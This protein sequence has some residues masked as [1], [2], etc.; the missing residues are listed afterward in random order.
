M[1]QR[2]RRDTYTD[3]TTLLSNIRNQRTNELETYTK[4]NVW[5]D[6]S[7]MNDSKVDGAV[8][9]KRG[10]E[11]FKKSFSDRII[12]CSIF[13][14]GFESLKKA[15]DFIRASQI[16]NG[17]KYSNLRLEYNSVYEITEQIVFQ[18]MDIHIDMNGSTFLFKTPIIANA[19]I[20]RFRN[21]NHLLKT[22]T[23]IEEVNGRTVLTCNNVTGL[24]KGQVIKL[25]SNDDLPNAPTRSTG[26]AALGECLFID[27][28]NTS[29]N[30]VTCT[31]RTIYNYNHS[32]NTTRISVFRDTQV[33]IRNGIFDAERGNE[34]NDIIFGNLLEFVQQ[35]N[36]IVSNIKCRFGYNSMIW[37][38][39]CWGYYINKLSVEFLVD[40]DTQER[41]GYGIRSTNSEAGT[42]DKCTFRNCRHGFV[43]ITQGTGTST[44]T[45]QFGH[46]AHH[47]ISNSVGAGCSNSPFD[48]HHG[49]YNVSF[50]NCK[51]YSNKQ[52]G[53]QLRGMYNSIDNC[54]SVND[55]AGVYIFIQTSYSNV[56]SQ[57]VK[58][59]GN[60]IN[61]FTCINPFSQAIRN[62]SSETQYVDGYT[63]I[64]DR[65]R[66]ST[67]IIRNGRDDSANQI[68]G[69]N[70]ILEG[71][72][73]ILGGTLE[74][75]NSP[76]IELRGNARKIEING[77]NLNAV[78][79][80]GTA[81]ELVSVNFTSAFT[82]KLRNF[83]VEQSAIK[84]RR[85][86]EGTAGN[87]TY[88]S[89]TILENIR[90]PATT[91]NQL[92]Q[93]LAVSTLSSYA[94]YIRGIIRIP[95]CGGVN[96]VHQESL[97]ANRFE[98]YTIATLPT[99]STR[100]DSISMIND[101]A[102]GKGRLIYSNGIV[103]RYVSD[104]STV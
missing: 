98:S 37:M 34:S 96:F 58:T 66:E 95:N 55:R 25:V 61:N 88:L 84:F 73:I 50:K 79:Y 100:A 43:S 59:A 64:L 51:S 39:G 24:E 92:F 21:T 60:R 3:G 5:A 15:C 40:N 30:K 45:Q 29:N 1:T 14:S 4:T 104:D 67:G 32:I 85:L 97:V 23:L 68:P 90:I 19:G 12:D 72:K 11:Y 46:D 74:I 26:A 18:N 93:G 31:A 62:E 102:A 7:V 63:I 49:S 57:L 42:V 81:F 103:W 75:L 38:F 36:P 48:T 2:H 33:S 13:G 53:Y 87:P 54:E 6:G 99:A 80:T 47:I 22:V 56:G 78:N 65:V 86:V 77:L 76:L 91:S 16:G 17:I 44:D 8:Y 101:P 52:A 35:K 89:D 70:L 83:E 94:P 69:G 82:L 27:S 71:G 41:R 28:I 10:T 20:I 9:V